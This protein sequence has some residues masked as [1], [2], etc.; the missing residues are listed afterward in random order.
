MVDTTYQVKYAC[1]KVNPRAEEVVCCYSIP[2]TIIID[3]YKKFH[4]FMTVWAG[5][6]YEN[7]GKSMA[8]SYNTTPENTARRKARV[9]LES[10]R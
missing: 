1:V 8:K 9:C 5:K 6:C 2:A 7:E 3:K 4:S 10:A